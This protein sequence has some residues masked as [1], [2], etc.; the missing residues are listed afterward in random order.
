LQS[1]TRQKMITPV[2]TDRDA[3]ANLSQPRI[4]KHRFTTHNQG[5]QILD[6]AR[7]VDD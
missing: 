7:D 3:S 5:S 4:K 2:I 1:R 6:G